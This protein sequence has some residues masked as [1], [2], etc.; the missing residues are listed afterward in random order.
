MNTDTTPIMPLEETIYELIHAK[1]RNNHSMRTRVALGAALH[2]LEAGKCAQEALAEL[3]KGEMECG[4]CTRGGE[5]Y[6]EFAR[7]SITH[8]TQDQA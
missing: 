4:H 3:A 7:R 5:T 1:D 2:H 6:D 8:P